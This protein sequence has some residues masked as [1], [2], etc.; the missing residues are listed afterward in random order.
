MD[1]FKTPKRKWVAV[2]VSP[3]RI[4]PDNGKASI[5]KTRKIVEAKTK[6]YET[7]YDKLLEKGPQY[8]D[9]ELRK[10]IKLLKARKDPKQDTDFVQEV[11]EYIEGMK[12]D[13]HLLKKAHK[14]EMEVANKL[15]ISN[16]Q[17]NEVL[18]KQVTDLIGLSK[19]TETQ[20]IELLA[21]V[22]TLETPAI[23]APGKKP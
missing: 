15:I 3:H 17:A 23:V 16:R 6:E 8:D 1:V 4:S 21:K 7:L 2:Q 11:I 22:R 13:L 5:A 10:E 20:V 18:H 14:E 9:S 19:T 12:E